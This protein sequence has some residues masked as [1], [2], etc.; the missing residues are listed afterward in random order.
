MWYLDGNNLLSAAVGSRTGGARERLLVR[1]A[2]F[3]LPSPCTVVFD[4]PPPPESKG[5]RRMGGL[6]V[7]YCAPRSADEVILA[8]VRPGDRVVTGDRDL[9][10]RCRDRQ[11]RVVPPQE[12]LSALKPAGRKD[13]EKPDA[14]AVDVQAWLKLF[15]GEES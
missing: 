4:G 6:S 9:A 2:N 5:R 10:L 13:A 11:A 15:G 1:L 7:V 8:R 12:F 3:R 14:T